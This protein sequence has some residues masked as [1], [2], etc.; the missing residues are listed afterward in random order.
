MT[1]AQGAEA[2]HHDAT[3]NDDTVCLI[4]VRHAAAVSGGLCV[5]WTDVPL[6]DEG[7]AQCEMLR[8][9]EGPLGLFLKQDD[10]PLRLESSDLARARETAEAIAGVCG[11]S[12]H[13]E[14]GLREMYFGEWDGRAWAS[15]EVEDAERLATWMSHWLVAA[16]PAGETVVQLQDRAVVLLRRILQ[17]P[18]R[19]FVL[20]SHAGWIRVALCLL[21]GKPVSEMF[22]LVVPHAQPIVVHVPRNAL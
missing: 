21:Q 12:V 17:R 1:S 16:P 19:R 20:V 15:L 2:E 11:F 4:L 8:A 6:S 13:E 7:R 3:G 22:D 5:G 18:E 9:P 10:S 14:Q